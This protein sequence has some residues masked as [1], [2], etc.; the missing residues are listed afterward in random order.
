MLL[1]TPVQARVVAV[2]VEKSITTPQYY[3]MSVNAVMMAANQKTA[4]FRS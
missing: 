2:L 4:V 3:P 1:L